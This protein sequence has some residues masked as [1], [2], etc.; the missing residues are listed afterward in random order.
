MKK[1]MKL[2][3]LLFAFLLLTNHLKAQIIPDGVYQ[4]Y[5]D[6]HQ[7]AMVTSL[8]GEFDVSMTPP[9]FSDNNQ[10]WNFSHQGGNVYKISNVATGSFIGIKDGWCGIFGD[11]QAR[12]AST[13]ANVEFLISKGNN[14]GSYVIQIAFT[15][16]NFGS[17]N[18]PVKAFDVQDGL[19]G[20]QIQ[21]FDVDFGGANQQFRLISH[22]WN[23]NSDT[24]WANTANWTPS[25]IPSAV[26]NVR[27]P[28]VTNKPIVNSNVGVHDIFIN[29]TQHCTKLRVF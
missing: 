29:T 4:I 8:S 7:E 15:T 27:V 21:T 1:E 11:V 24:D 19:S 20:A 2:S 26:S 23:G 22:E 16:C 17:V 5:S 10:L 14:S 25:S 12:Y 6:V 13:D 18:D 3:Y 9:N 28:N